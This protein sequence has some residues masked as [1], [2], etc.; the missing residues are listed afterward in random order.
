MSDAP[1]QEGR[2]AAGASGAPAPA[3]PAPSY[4]QDVR[5]I[6]VQTALGKDALLLRGLQGEEGLSRLFTFDLDLLCEQPTIDVAAVMGKSATVGMR[7]ADGTDRFF[8]G[9]ISRIALTGAEGR[10]T[11][12]RAELVPWLWLLTRR[13]DCRAFQNLPVPAIVEKVFKDAGFLD[14]ANRVQKVY[15]PREYTVQYRETDFNFVSRILEQ[16]GI[17]YFFQHEN[18][19]HTLVLADTPTEHPPC[20]GLAPARF[21]ALSPTDYEADVISGWAVA[22][23]IRP[24]RYSLGAYNFEAPNANLLVNVDSVHATPATAKYEIY[25]F[26][27][28]YQKRDDGEKL[29][30]LRIEEQET[31]TITIHGSSTCRTLAA[32]HRF[33]LSEHPSSVQNQA[34]VVTSVAHS[35]SEPSYLSK[36]D[37]GAGR[38]RNTFT[39]VPASAPFRPP[40]TT[41]RPVIHGVQTA[42][43]VGPKGEELFVDKYG[44]VKVQFHW[45][46]AGNYDE[47]SSGWIRVSQNWAGKRWGAMFLPRIGQEVIVEFLEGDPDFPLITGRVYNADQNTPYTLP[48]EQTKTALKSSS[49]KGGGGFNEL[50]FDDKKGAEQLFIHGQ[51]DLDF[52]IERESRELVG[53]DRHLIVTKGRFEQVGGEQHLK[54]NADFV[55]QVDGVRYLGAGKGLQVT[56]GGNIVI[57][58]KGELTLKGPGGFIVLGA[59]GITIQ[60]KLVNINSGGEAGAAMS[61][62]VKLPNRASSAGA[63]EAGGIDGAG[64]TEQRD[65]DLERV[66]LYRKTY[67]ENSDK[68]SEEDKKEYQAALAELEAATARRDAAGIAAAKAKLDAILTKNKIP[69]PADPATQTAG[70]GGIASKAAGGPAGGVL[71]GRV[72]VDGRFFVNDAGNFRPVFQSGLAL[73]AQPQAQRAAFLDETAALGFNGVRVFAGDLGWANQ[74]PAS[75]RAALPA[76]L[77]EAAAR[78]LYVYVCA[79]TGG[80]EPVY[81]IEAHLRAITEMAAAHPNTILEVANEIGHPTLSERANDV[82]GLLSMARRIIPPGLTWTL[83]APLST[84]EPT[85]QG[86]YPTD[87]GM[88]ND[89]HLDRGR[90][91]WNQVRRVRE[92]AALSDAT[93]KPAMS[94]EPI[95]A[96]EHT[97]PG[98]RESDPTFFFTLGALSRGFE[99]GSVFHSEAGLRGQLLGPNQRRCAQEFIAGWKALATTGRLQFVNAG[100]VP[101]NPSVMPHFSG[102]E[103]VYSFIEGNRGWSVVVGAKNP[104]FEFGSGWRRGPTVAERPGLIIFEI[105]K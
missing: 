41:P 90:D 98:K 75:A 25:D 93:R 77:T 19:K 57:E 35:A 94:G 1:R 54:V 68:M 22:H 85:P 31:Q 62:T 83:G 4:S 53:V 101:P 67:E 20:V 47:N 88:F 13:S 74:T 99:V 104:Q 66:E 55:E 3:A 14:F 11:T 23:E 24:A 33:D 78:G 69:I 50:R 81:D 38:Y 103:R 37:S 6:A 79:I 92:I 56:A 46:R 45:D 44:R 32:G 58:T 2:S 39:A 7:L 34:Y 9:I 80:K 64:T 48:D 21:R 91:F 71:A 30:S 43:V 16:A 49:T 96:A 8:N 105:L 10:F 86:T 89:A 63:G 72:R 60:G 17:F 82:R 42:V 28:D 18:G 102:A 65:P 87:G 26:P 61:K 51:R 29:V 12:Y 95:G 73:L 59:A 70:P 100:W 15:P 52:V 27:G 40:R 97:Q 5:S 76:L 84:D 36:K